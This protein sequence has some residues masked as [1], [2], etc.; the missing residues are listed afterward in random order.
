MTV[1]FYGS[2]SK[3]TN[4]DKSFTPKNH[5]TLQS[6][7]DELGDNYGEGFSSFITGNE[8]CLFLINGIGVKLTGGL[9][10]PLKEGDKIEILPFV[11]A[12]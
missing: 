5:P 1:T 6:L 10:S 3:H 8:T 7:L 4:G 11:D 12:G 2:I 9:D